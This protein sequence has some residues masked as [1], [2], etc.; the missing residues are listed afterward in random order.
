MIRNKLQRDLFYVSPNLTVEILI[1][2]S[3][4]MDYLVT[5]RIVN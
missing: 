3:G 2:G 4:L 5:L 1:S